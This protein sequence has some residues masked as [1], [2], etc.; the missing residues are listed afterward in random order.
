MS[1]FFA[2]MVVCEIAVQA[3]H[4][5]D[6]GAE[7]ASSSTLP[8]PKQKPTAAFFDAV[9]DA[10]LVGLGHQAGHRRVGALAPFD[11]VGAHRHHPLLR[12]RRAFAGLALAVHV[13]DQGDILVAGHLLRALDRRLGDAE[14][15]RHHQQQRTLAA[16]LLVP[17]Q[18]VLGFD[19]AA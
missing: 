1:P 4:G 9:A 17:H 16:D 11:A 6:V 12:G 3:D 7:R 10:A 18:R 5:V 8:P 15:V 14:P 19:A 13:G 2:G